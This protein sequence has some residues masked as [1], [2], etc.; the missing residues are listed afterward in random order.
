MNAVQANINNVTSLWARAASAFDRYVEA[1]SFNYGYIPGSDWPNKIWLHEVPTAAS[2]GGIASLM[3]EN[4]PKLSFSYF[5]TGSAGI[6]E[7]ILASGFQELHF[8]HGM[9]LKPEQPF[10][11]QSPLKF[12]AVEKLQDIRDWCFVFEKAFGYHISPETLARTLHSIDYFNIQS[13]GRT[14]GTMAHSWTGKVMGLY[15][16]GVLPEARG[17][18]VARDAMHFALNRALI[19]EAE[20]VILQA[21]QMGLPMYAR[22]GFATDFIMRTYKLKTI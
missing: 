3:A 15:S 14:I 4:C 8:L 12:K 18:G 19:R 16:M 2:L 20:L 7:Q 22:L 6:T 11:N 17:K 13:A 1:A 10:D 21:S 5:D 9:S